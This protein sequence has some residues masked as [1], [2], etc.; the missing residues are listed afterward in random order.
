M[1]QG[2]ARALDDRDDADLLA[3]HVGGDR[4]AFGVLFGRHR[5][6]L[7]AVALRTTGNPDDAADA[8]QDAMI[9]AFR[10]AADY[11]GESAVTTWLH[12]IVV[13]A[14][15]DRLRRLKVRATRPLPD[16]LEEYAERGSLVSAA[17]EALDPA[18]VLIGS[19]RRARVLAALEQIPPDQKAALVLVDLQGY[20]VQE[21]ARILD[22]PVGT[23]KSRCARGRTRL[24]PLLRTLLEPPDPDAGTR[25]PP[26][27]SNLQLPGGDP[28]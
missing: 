21:A 22:C 11:R 15:L 13:N 14:A 17:D 10:R 8:L 16:D 7:W 9:S 26:A 4:D 12:R 18:E 24:A 2:A 3:A 5:D 27:P 19:D 1:T 20:P 6:R 28:Q 25:Q 23:V